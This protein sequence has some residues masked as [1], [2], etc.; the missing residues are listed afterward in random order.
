M[1]YL[2]KTFS[3]YMSSSRSQNECAQCHKTDNYLYKVDD[4]FYCKSCYDNQKSWKYKVIK[5]IDD[6]SYELFLKNE[7]TK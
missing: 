1:N 2:N 3:V 6:L 4:M 7:N 5:F